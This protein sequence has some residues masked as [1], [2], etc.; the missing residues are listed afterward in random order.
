MNK[1]T[2]TASALA[3]AL[4][5]GAAF[6]G[7]TY[8]HGGDDDDDDRRGGYGMMGHMGGGMMGSHHG[9]DY[10]HGYGHGYGMMGFGGGYRGDCPFADKAS[11]SKD[12]TVE[13][14]TKF[15]EQRLTHMGND[16]LKVGEVK[17]TDDKTI[18][19]EIVTKDGSLVM[20]MQF[21]RATGRHVP[22]K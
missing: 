11:F 2:L 1:K 10:D 21:D 19:G 4:V 15:L 9:R 14:V 18:V 12:V 3:A 22:I 8:A 16:R 20:K 17:A 7:Q 6:A 13:S 5:L